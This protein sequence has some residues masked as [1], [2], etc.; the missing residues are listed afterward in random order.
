MIFFISVIDA[1]D[2]ENI[3]KSKIKTNYRFFSKN[4]R[5]NY[6]NAFCNVIMLI[7]QKQSFMKFVKIET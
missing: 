1:V 5:P 3:Y 2:M 6:E 4:N 7:Q